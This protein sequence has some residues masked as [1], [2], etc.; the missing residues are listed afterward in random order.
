MTRPCWFMLVC[1]LLA[2]GAPR[3]TARA[4]GVVQG[5]VVLAGEAP[6]PKKWDLDEPITRLTGEKSYA[7]ET[8][9]VGKNGG[10]ANCVVVLRAKNPKDRIAAK[11]LAGAVVDKVGVRYLP[12]VLA[13]TPGTE[14]VLRNKESPCRGFKIEGKPLLDHSYNFLVREGTEVK[15]AF[16][17][18]D[19][20]VAS[21]PLRPYTRGF[22]H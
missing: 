19:V 17:G 18:L 8:W 6:T 21:C 2:L 1:C 20:C 22:I 14:V 5:T 4:E 9:L 13:V 11:P 7:D 15:A 3:G 12:R 10:L 16:K